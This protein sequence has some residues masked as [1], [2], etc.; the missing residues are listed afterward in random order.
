MK[1]LQGRL[2]AAAVIAGAIIA[3]LSG[4]GSTPSDDSLFPATIGQYRQATDSKAYAAGK[5][6]GATLNATDGKSYE[7]AV[8]RQ[9]LSELDPDTHAKVQRAQ[10][11]LN[12]EQQL[13]LVME[14]RS[15]N[16]TTTSFQQAVARTFNLNGAQSR[17]QI[18]ETGGAVV[19]IIPGGWV[20][21]GGGGA[22]GTAPVRAYAHVL[23]SYLA[24]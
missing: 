9:I 20:V 18:I 5:A 21:A 22:G 15:P 19:T 2:V 17:K 12:T 24:K 8:T 1:S 13:F 11:Y 10:F 7:A 16:L 4:C 14:V 23:Q 6:V 3:A